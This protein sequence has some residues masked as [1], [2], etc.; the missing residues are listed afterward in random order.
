[1]K[2]IVEGEELSN[3]GYAASCEELMLPADREVSNQP[4]KIFFFHKS[5]YQ[6]DS[7]GLDMEKA[8]KNFTS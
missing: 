8:K 2:L 6:G 3:R 4:S 7:W 5:L 1:M